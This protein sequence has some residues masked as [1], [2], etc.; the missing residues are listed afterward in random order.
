MPHFSRPSP[1]NQQL[2]SQ[3]LGTHHILRLLLWLIKTLFLLP[4]ISIPTPLAKEKILYCLLSTHLHYTHSGS[5]APRSP[6]SG[7]F[8]C[9]LHLPHGPMREDSVNS[10]SFWLPVAFAGG[11]RHL[12]ATYSFLCKPSI[13]SCHFVDMSIYYFLLLLRFTTFLRCRR[14]RS[15]QICRYFGKFT[16]VPHLFWHPRLRPH[17]AA[18]RNE[19]LSKYFASISPA[20]HSLWHKLILQHDVKVL[21]TRREKKS[22]VFLGL[23]AAAN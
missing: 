21:R 10:S 5:P 17:P 15:V 18:K 23:L 20:L 14:G 2:L 7:A 6:E 11:T 22:P 8:R 19:I 4:S 9:S 1:R 16:A 13:S 3:L 12:P